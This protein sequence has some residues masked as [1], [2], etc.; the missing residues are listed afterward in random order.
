MTQEA[1]D[2]KTIHLGQANIILKVFEI[3]ALIGTVW[4]AAQKFT[5]I[6]TA[7]TTLTKT[8]ERIEAKTDADREKLISAINRITSIEARTTRNP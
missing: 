6:E 5:L 7:I 3:V 4:L 1:T 2:A 8:A